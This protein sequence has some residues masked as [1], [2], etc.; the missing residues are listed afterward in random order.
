M[1]HD[2]IK[3]TRADSGTTLKHLTIQRWHQHVRFDQ[4]NTMH[5]MGFYKK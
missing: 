1:E 2:D 4:V 3:A 5:P